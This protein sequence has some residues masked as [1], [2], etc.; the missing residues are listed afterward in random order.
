M[1][2]KRLRTGV[3]LVFAASVLVLSACADLNKNMRV[4]TAKVDHGPPPSSSR[5]CN[6]GICKIEVSVDAN[7]NVSVEPSDVY[8]TESKKIEWEIITA[9]HV[10]P[11]DGILY[12]PNP[13]FELDAGSSRKIRIQNLFTKPTNPPSKDYTVSYE[14]KVKIQ[15]ASD[16]KVCI[17]DPWIRNSF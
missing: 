9:G 3:W 10:F 11:P 12:L 15:R 17:K 6:A 13:P 4:T 8:L 7:C 16:G 1:S 2:Q 14:Y 5:P